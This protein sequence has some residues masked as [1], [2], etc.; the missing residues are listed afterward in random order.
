MAD[1]GEIARYPATY[2]PTMVV[3]VQPVLPLVPRCIRTVHA[4][5]SA[6]RLAL[7]AGRDNAEGT[8]TQPSLYLP[9][10][11]LIRLRIPVA[12]GSR[13]VTVKARQPSGLLPRPTARLLPNA[14]IGLNAEVSATA[15]AGPGW[16]SIGP[17]TFTATANGGVFVELFAPWSGGESGCWF[18]AL[19][20]A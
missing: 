19:T 12:A 18:D 8:S 13:A 9:Q 16:V 4:E 10:G 17:L 7:N 1:H 3:Q 5:P 11:G 20:V 14:A 6:E 2:L 15:P